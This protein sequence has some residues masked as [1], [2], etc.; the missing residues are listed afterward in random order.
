[1]DWTSWL[2]LA[3]SAAAT[4]GS[5]FGDI[6]HDIASNPAKWTYLA[7]DWIIRLAM[8]PIV[9]QRRRPDSAMA[10]LLVIFFEPIVGLVLYLLIGE[11]RLPHRRLNRHARLLKKL[12]SLLTRFRQHPNIVRPQVSSNNAPAVKLAERLGYMP[13]LGGN[14]MDVL[15]QTDGFIDRLIAD[16]DAAQDHVHLLFYIYVDDETGQRVSAALARAVDRGVT[17][18]L[19]VD[20][21]GSSKFIKHAS[22]RVRGQGIDVRP[23]L[24]V[25]LIRRRFSR[26]DMRNHRKLVV[27]DG[28]IAY[29]GSQN[30]VNP[31]YGKRKLVW[32]D[33]MIRLTG[34]ITLEL[35]AVFLSDWYHETEEIL[36]ADG[37]FPDPRIT[38][39]IPAQT[40]PSGPSYP[41]ENYQRMAL[42]AIHGAS[43]QV[44]IT[45]PYFVPDEPLMQA[46]QVAVLRGVQVRVIAPRKLDQILVG[47]AARAFYHDLLE[48]GAELHLFTEGLLHAKTMTVDDEL[49]LVGTAN[50]DIR[51][52]ALNFELNV[53]LYQQQA[54]QQ[55]V[56]LQEDYV[57]RCRQVTLAEWNARSRGKRL[58]ENI[59]RLMSPLL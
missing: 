44:T 23:V 1:M 15:A 19:L 53:L 48:I 14:E 28:R 3:Q 41:T 59:V 39:E 40:L 51:S 4:Q 9:T 47:A 37:L 10:W 20:A 16:I 11:D 42:T 54:T 22:E 49:A 58:F 57:S 50:F 38:G 5:F 52:F 55:I 12:Q 31:N 17:C 2:V 33:M 18:R 34:P 32:H 25:G 29:T 26:I 8:I 13:I 27:I 46:I 35:Q 24:S 21:V 45:T 30:I 36:E 7:I 43:R 6:L 56:D